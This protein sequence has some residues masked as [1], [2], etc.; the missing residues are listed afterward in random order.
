[1]GVQTCAL[2]ISPAHPLDQAARGEQAG[3]GAD[4]APADLQRLR[5]LGGAL[6]RRVA[7]EQPPDDAPGDER[8]ALGGE[9][10]RDV[11]DEVEFGVR[12][13]GHGPIVRP[14]RDSPSPA[15]GGSRR[16][17]RSRDS[18]SP[19][20]GDAFR[21]PGLRESSCWASGGSRR[22]SAMRALTRPGSCRFG[23]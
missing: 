23:Q 11:I 22:N 9:E 2:P 6:L 13:Y 12:W 21:D 20:S 15:P 8:Q 5:Q 18:L 1:T 3:R 7:D 14:S 10:G 4:G 19:A 17:S 16:N